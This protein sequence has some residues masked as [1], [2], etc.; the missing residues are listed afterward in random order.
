MMIIETVS[1]LN[2]FE[3]RKYHFYN[4]ILIKDNICLKKFVI[5]VKSQR[6]FQLLLHSI[7]NLKYQNYIFLISYR[8]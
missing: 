5:V 6:Q 4:R 8:K 2:V 1:F 3:K 7:I